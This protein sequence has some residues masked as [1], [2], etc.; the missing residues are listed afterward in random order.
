MANH[1]T[2]IAKMLGMEMEEEFGIRELTGGKFKLTMRGMAF[3]SECGKVWVDV[4]EMLGHLLTD[5]FTI[6]RKPFVPKRRGEEY[7]VY[8][9][10][11]I[12]RRTWAD[13]PVDLSYFCSGNC[14]RTEQEALVN[15]GECARKLREKYLQKYKSNL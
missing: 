2:E 12:N 9:E 5:N 8:D 14:F 4:P 7:Y 10:K 1:M 6:V 13:T 15:G 11:I 3:Q